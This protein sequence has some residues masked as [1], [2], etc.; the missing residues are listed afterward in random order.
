MSPPA[1]DP[2]SAEDHYRLAERLLDCARVAFEANDY[3]KQKAL[4]DSAG[5]HYTAALAAVAV[6][7]HDVNVI[8]GLTTAVSLAQDELCRWRRGYAAAEKYWAGVSQPDPSSPAPEGDLDVTI[9]AG[10]YRARI[11]K[12]LL[13]PGGLS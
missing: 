5:V 6:W 11:Q 8:T 7:P 2:M 9:G 3:T 10:A 1:A 13:Q 12:A 4:L